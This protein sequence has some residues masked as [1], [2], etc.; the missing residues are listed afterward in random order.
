MDAE[1]KKIRHDTIHNVYSNGKILGSILLG[2]LQD[3]GHLDYD[4]PVV[5]YWPEFGQNGKDQ[6]TIRDVL[7]H[8]A[9]LRRFSEPLPCDGSFTAG[10]LKNDI[11]SIIE[12]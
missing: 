8:E 4:A 11:G 3:Q 2:V 1:G 12:K 7:S 6:I 5:K 10:L 9:G